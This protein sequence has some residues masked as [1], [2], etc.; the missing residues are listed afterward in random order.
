MS[1]VLSWSERKLLLLIENKMNGNKVPV[2]CMSGR[3]FLNEKWCDK[4]VCI[5]Y[6]G[7][8]FVM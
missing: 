5:W 6:N 1:E 7:S 4:D 2:W 8:D 3:D